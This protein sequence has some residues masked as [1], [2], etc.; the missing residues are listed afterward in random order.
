MCTYSPTQ[1]SSLLPYAFAVHLLQVPRLSS[2]VKV[3]LEPLLHACH[4]GDVRQVCG[5][6][7]RTAKTRP[8]LQL[9]SSFKPLLKPGPRHPSEAASSG[10]RSSNPS[11]HNADSSGVINTQHPVSGSTPLSVACSAGQRRVVQLLLGA[12]ADC[13]QH[14]AQDVSPL[15][16]AARGGHQAVVQVIMGLFDACL[17]IFP[18]HGYMY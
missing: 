14:D 18:C 5:F 17:P 13:Y 8:L 7:W 16:W 1:S 12:G 4:S 11:S 10:E 15:M 3:W 2:D 9:A 6:I